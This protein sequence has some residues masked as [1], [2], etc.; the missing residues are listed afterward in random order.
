MAVGSEASARLREEVLPA[1]PGAGLHCVLC[2]ILWYLRQGQLPGGGTG[3]LCADCGGGPVSYLS[4][5][6]HPS[7]CSPS[8]LCC[9]PITSSLSGSDLFLDPLPLCLFL[10]SPSPFFNSS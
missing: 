1:A 4:L 8:F 5:S 2:V 3:W 10:V 6:P 9:L 7:P